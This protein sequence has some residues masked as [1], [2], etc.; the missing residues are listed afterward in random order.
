MGKSDWYDMREFLQFL[1][2]KNDLLRIREE[3]DP[4]WE[5]NGI[6]RITLQQLG[7]CLFFEKIK[8]ADYPLVTN[9]ITTDNRL[10]WSLGIVKWHQLDQR[11]FPGTLSISITKDPDTGGL[12]AGIY[13]METEGKNQLGWGA[14]EYTH[15]RQIYMKYERM[16]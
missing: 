10:L 13:R 1:E 8:G 7:P 5:I 3:V 4:D 16:G 12:N 6:T 9:L 15:G 11:P 14:P 2:S